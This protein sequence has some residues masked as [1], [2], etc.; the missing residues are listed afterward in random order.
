[1][2]NLAH[3]IGVYIYTDGN[4]Y[5]GEW[6]NGLKHGVGKVTYKNKSKLGIWINGKRQKW[7]DECDDLNINVK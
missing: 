2:N 3:G 1:M 7:L 6:I 5:D 4:K